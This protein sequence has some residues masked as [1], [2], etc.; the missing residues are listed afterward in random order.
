MGREPIEDYALIGDA[1]TAALCS[2]GGSIDWLCL[3][4]F[5]SEPVFGKLLGGG[6]AGSFSLSVDGARE[7]S[8]RY[9]DGSAVLETTWH[10]RSSAVT[11]T[12]AMVLDVSRTL[13][14]QALLVRRLECRGA[15]TQVRI[16]FDPRVGLAGTQPRREYRTGALICTWGSLALAL[17]SFPEFNL[18]AGSDKTIALDDG[19][20]VTF[21]LS[22][23]DRAPVVLMRPE[24]AFDLLEETDR[25]WRSWSAGLVYGGPFRDAVVRSL[26]TLRLL[27]Y[28]PSGAP[29]AAPTTSLPEV[30]GGTRNWDYRFSWPRDASIGLAA[31]LAVGKNEEAHSFMHWLLHA[32][33]LT[34]PRLEVLY[35]VF[36]K[37]G[38]REREL[39]DV[40]GYRGSI[41]V[42]I[43]NAA[44]TQHQLDVYGWVLDAAWLLASSGRKLHGETWRALAGFADF[45]A[46]RWR[47][48]DAGIWEVRG[49]P[50]HYVHSKLMGWLA[51]DRATR[52][53]RSYRIRGARL[54][55]W[56]AERDALSAEVRERGFDDS[57][58]TYLW[59][60][61][62]TALDA[63]LLILP[64][65]EFEEEDSPRL[66][67]TVAAVRRELS[68]GGPLLYRYRRGADRLE[69]AEG[70]FAPCS[71]WLVQALAR[72]GRVE[73]SVE[74]FEELLSYSNDVGLLPEEIDPTTGAYLGNFP[75][76]FSHATLV[77][78]ALAIQA[79][80]RG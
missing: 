31:F 26:I 77:Q 1:R 20:V 52:L 39:L 4:R 34:R 66:A 65:L 22:L 55:R 50:A 35:T 12:D 58:G 74:L 51:L 75:Q 37:P 79:A 80:S 67:G 40:P 60:Y 14:P 29:V 16:H 62:S 43:G 24:A 6:Q 56:I 30:V 71:F 36:G 17:Q 11:L 33:R 49:E 69:G 25:W 5:D 78:A 46:E 13:R 72:L 59:S 3:P 73:E 47:G 7:T 32:S 61:G 54:A 53:A 45:V 19:S 2:S 15:S 57:R 27:T 64:V 68:A 70:A 42:R 8:R 10:M 48:P 76:A 44:S 23:A 63:A 21:V 28:A 41:P 38:P 9:R 18:I